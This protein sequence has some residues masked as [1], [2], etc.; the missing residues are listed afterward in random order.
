MNTVALG[1]NW[2]ILPHVRIMANY[3]LAHVNNLGDSDIF[4]LRFQIDY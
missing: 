3:I 2:Y 4:Q 1:L